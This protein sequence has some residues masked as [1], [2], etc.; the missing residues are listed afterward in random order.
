M[1]LRT[2]LHRN[3]SPPM[4]GRDVDLVPCEFRVQFHHKT[5]IHKG[6]SVGSAGSV[7]GV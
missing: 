6:S 4:S 7:C 5:L 1:E 2:E 3:Y